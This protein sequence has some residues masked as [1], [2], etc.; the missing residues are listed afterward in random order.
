MSVITDYTTCKDGIAKL[1]AEDTADFLT[2]MTDMLEDKGGG[3]VYNIKIEDV[4]DDP[5]LQEGKIILE[6]FILTAL[7]ALH[8]A[9]QC[10]CKYWHRS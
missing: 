1:S 6:K 10:A 3:Y 5:T 9:H 2:E 8:K 7:T 4:P